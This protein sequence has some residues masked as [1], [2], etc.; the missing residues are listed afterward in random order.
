VPCLNLVQELKIGKKRLFIFDGKELKYF[1]NETLKGQ[2][3]IEIGQTRVTLPKSIKTQP[4]PHLFQII[5]P[6]KTLAM[7]ALNL[8]A[9]HEWIHLLKKS[10]NLSVN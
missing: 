4:T 3:T 2:I 1:D 8:K 6:T 7:C 10:C 9:K 5:T